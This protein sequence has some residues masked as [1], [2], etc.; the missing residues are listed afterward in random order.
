[1]VPSLIPQKLSIVFKLSTIVDVQMTINQRFYVDNYS[2]YSKTLHN[3]SI[4][5]KL[6]TLFHS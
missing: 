1:M 2:L 3:S 6:E 5:L 4:I